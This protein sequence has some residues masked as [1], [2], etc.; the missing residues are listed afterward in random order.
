M[1]QCDNI[2]SAL[3]NSSRAYNQTN[4]GLFMENNCYAL[5]CLTN[6][7]QSCFTSDITSNCS[8]NALTYTYWQNKSQCASIPTNLTFR[9][10]IDKF[11]SLKEDLGLLL[12]TIPDEIVVIITDMSIMCI[13]VPVPLPIN[14]ALPL[15]SLSKESILQMVMANQDFVAKYVTAPGDVNGG[16]R[17]ICGLNPGAPPTPHDDDADE[18]AC[19][20]KA[21]NQP[22]ADQMAYSKVASYCQQQQCVC[23]GAPPQTPPEQ[24][25]NG[26]LYTN[27]TNLVG[28]SLDQSM[29]RLRYGHQY[30]LKFGCDG[31][32][33]QTINQDE[34]SKTQKVCTQMLCTTEVFNAMSS[35]DIVSLCTKAQRTL[36]E[37][38]GNVPH[39]S[40]NVTTGSTWDISQQE[41]L[42]AAVAAT[43]KVNATDVVVFV[44]VVGT[45][46]IMFLN[47]AD[48]TSLAT[49]LRADAKL[50]SDFSILNV[51]NS[52]GVLS[53]SETRV[54]ATRI[55]DIL[56][57]QMESP[58]PTFIEVSDPPAPLVTGVSSDDDSQNRTKMVLIPI[59]VGGVCLLLLVGCFVA[60]KRRVSARSSQQPR[61]DAMPSPRDGTPGGPTITTAQEMSPTSTT[62]MVAKPQ[63]SF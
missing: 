38:S 29:C 40:L 8:K 5:T 11:K 4:E 46:W 36:N 48:L 1:K 23:M 32:A 7:T 25:G 43:C 15:L 10:P 47:A 62:T 3:V 45:V 50:Q 2:R 6:E 28:C 16:V 30:H 60:W 31:L 17:M 53:P 13:T 34:I 49:L 21:A 58:F 42:T 59:I 51:T 24:C 52:A 37:I 39:L 26:D 22:L 56:P 57:P 61:G 12:N 35:D 55:V 18:K 27:L 41:K 54:I 44:P 33:N 9:Y 14:R 63:T 19:S 20:A